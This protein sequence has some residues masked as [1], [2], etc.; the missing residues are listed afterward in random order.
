MNE[1]KIVVGDI[2]KLKV[3][4]IVS[5]T[6]A[7]D[8]AIAGFLAALLRETAPERALQMA[9]LAARRCITSADTVSRIEP[10]PD[11]ER[12]LAAQPPLIPTALPKGWEWDGANG[13]YRVV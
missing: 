3:D 13:V 11:M 6:G 12:A 5:A 2:T 7:G 8:T 1:I 9:S 4:A 10:F